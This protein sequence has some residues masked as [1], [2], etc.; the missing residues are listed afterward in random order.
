VL[1]RCANA[2]RVHALFKDLRKPNR[3]G[4]VFDGATACQKRMGEIGLP[5]AD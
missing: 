4:L 2:H 1:S 3:C 5:I